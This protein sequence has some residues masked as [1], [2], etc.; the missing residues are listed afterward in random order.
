L[1]N[2]TYCQLGVRVN[3]LQ[4]PDVIAIV[5]HWIA[6]R[7]PARYIAVTGMHGMTEAQKDPQ[8]KQVLNSPRSLVAEWI[9]RDLF[10]CRIGRTSQAVNQRDGDAR[11]DK[12]H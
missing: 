7:E 2:R 6:C 1:L 4:I 5:E 8:F 10:P 12:K 9:L 11:N 3:A